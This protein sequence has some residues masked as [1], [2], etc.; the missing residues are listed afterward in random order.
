MVFLEVAEFVKDVGFC[1]NFFRN[2]KTDCFIF[3]FL[4][5][6]KTQIFFFTETKEKGTK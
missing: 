3:Y 5:E 4:I 6:L 2:V 1:E